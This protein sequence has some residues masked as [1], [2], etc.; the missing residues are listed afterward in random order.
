VTKTEMV[1]LLAQTDIDGDNRLIGDDVD[2]GAD[3]YVPP[4]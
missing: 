3:E 1:Y 4:Q 2:M